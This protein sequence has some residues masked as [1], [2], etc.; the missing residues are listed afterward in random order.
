MIDGGS[1]RGRCRRGR[2][3]CFEFAL[4]FVFQPILRPSGLYARAPQLIADKQKHQQ[5][6]GDQALADPRDH[7]MPVV[8]W[9]RSREVRHTAALVATPPLQRRSVRVLVLAFAFALARTLA[10][11]CHE[12]QRYRPEDHPTRRLH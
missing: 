10:A 5:S 9:L 12:N 8:F 4:E 1:C 11:A 3:R 7:P 2:R 6:E